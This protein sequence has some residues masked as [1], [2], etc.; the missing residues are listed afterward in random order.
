MRNWGRLRA[1]NSF[2]VREPPP[3]FRLDPIYITVTYGSSDSHW[4]EV[5]R[6]RSFCS[7]RWSIGK[8][9]TCGGLLVYERIRL[10]QI[11]SIDCYA[12]N[13]WIVEQILKDGLH[14]TDAECMSYTMGLVDGLEQ[15]N[16]LSL[17]VRHMSRLT[18][19]DK[20]GFQGR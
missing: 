14:H 4:P 3:R 6:Y 5:G 20:V 1:Q 10:A 9:E 8:G 15:V 7:S 2:C 16:I 11:L 13:Y 17:T 19:I 12:G 18:E